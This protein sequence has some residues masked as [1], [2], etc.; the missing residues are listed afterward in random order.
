MNGS[1]LSLILV[2]VGLWCAC[3]RGPARAAPTPSGDS[4]WLREHALEREDR[5]KVCVL[6]TI[7]LAQQTGD[8]GAAALNALIEQLGRFRPDLVAVER[9]PGETTESWLRQAPAMDELLNSFAADAASAGRLAQHAL[10]INREQAEGQFAATLQ[11]FRNRP[12]DQ[13]SS[14]DRMRAAT[15]SAASFDL[16]SAALQW[17]YTHADQR[18][19]RDVLSDELVA[20]FNKAS[21]SRSEDVAVGV[22]LARRLNLQRVVPIDDQSD[23]TFQLQHGE[24]LMEQLQQSPEFK[25]L[26]ESMLM[27]ELPQRISQTVKG[28]DVLGL[29]RWINSP[30]YARADVDAQWHIFMRTRLPSGLDRSRAACWEARNLAI[31]GNL[32]KAMASERPSR[33]LVIIGASHRPFLEAYLGQMMDVE[34]VPPAEILGP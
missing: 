12:A 7:H 15:L 25:K 13:V 16:D 6:G 33:V 10:N 34:I 28:G 3:T 1:R 18:S 21:Q 27:T 8:V 30:E 2:P 29:Y 23:A 22:A 31:A 11:S 19:P 4:A 20:A 5:T 9:V 24:A 17:S 14:S 26:Q 32:R